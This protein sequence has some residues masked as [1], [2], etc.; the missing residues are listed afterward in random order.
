MPV[1]IRKSLRRLK[2]L[3]NSNGNSDDKKKKIMKARRAT[4]IKTGRIEVS[5]YHIM[6]SPWTG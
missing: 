5:V 4:L 3:A 6:I 1:V 2:C